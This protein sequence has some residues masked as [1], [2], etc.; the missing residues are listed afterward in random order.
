MIRHGWSGC[1]CRYLRQTHRPRRNSL[2]ITGRSWICVRQG[3]LL[4][5]VFHRSK[6]KPRR[7]LLELPS[8]CRPSCSHSIRMNRLIESVASVFPLLSDS[9]GRFGC[10]SNGTVRLLSSTHNVRQARVTHRLAGSSLYW[11]NPRIQTSQ[12]FLIHLT[13]LVVQAVAPARWNV[14]RHQAPGLSRGRPPRRHRGRVF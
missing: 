1:R 12:R 5:I 8:I 2:P 6:M 10:A 3:I 7:V 13:E 11:R 4:Y 9:F 14:R